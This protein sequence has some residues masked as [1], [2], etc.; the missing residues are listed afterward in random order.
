[1]AFPCRHPARGKHYHHMFVPFSSCGGILYEGSIIIM[2]LFRFQVVHASCTRE[3]LSS[4]VLFRFQ[5]VQASCT[6]REALSSCVCSVFKLYSRVRGKRYHHVFVPCSSCTGILYEGSIIMCLFRFQV[7]RASCRSIESKSTEHKKSSVKFWLELFS[8]SCN[9]VAAQT[10][11]F[12][13]YSKFLLI[14]P[15]YCFFFSELWLPHLT[16]IYS[17]IS[18]LGVLLQL[19]KHLISFLT[20][21]K[22]ISLCLCFVSKD[23]NILN[24]FYIQREE[25]MRYAYLFHPSMCSVRHILSQVLSPWLLHNLDITNS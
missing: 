25:E 2:C 16:L 9:Q 10:V 5:V 18:L 19:G 22:L 24:N 14:M 21:I 1:M 12:P 20:L 3:A 17:C 4:C 11:F 8:L 23:C 13:S 15:F 6:R 7:L